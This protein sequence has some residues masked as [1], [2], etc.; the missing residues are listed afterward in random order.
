MKPTSPP[1]PAAEPLHE[2]EDARNSV[3]SSASAVDEITRLAAWICETPI[4]LVTL[5]DGGAH[6]LESVT[7][8]TLPSTWLDT[9][10]SPHTV[11]QRGVLLISD[12]AADHRVA[13]AP[14]VAGEPH[15]RFYAGTPLLDIDGQPIGALSAMDS[16]TRSLTREQQSALQILGRQVVAQLELRDQRL[17][18]EQTEAISDVRVRAGDSVAVQG[19]E[20]FAD[21]LDEECRR[22]GRYNRPLSLLLLSA[23]SFHGSFDQPADGLLSAVAHWL[24]TSARSSDVVGCL[25]P[26]EFAVLLTDTDHA[27][28]LVLGERFRQI[29]TWA[30]WEHG[31]VLVHAGIVS[32][33]TGGNAS[34]LVQEA[35]SALR[36]AQERSATT[37]SPA[38]H[39]R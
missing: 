2:R 23:D 14:I 21:R 8:L 4:A 16:V 6:R 37:V 7:G 9:C 36:R 32:L 19:S 33:A 30:G 20:A 22:A 27:G 29:V 11:K 39:A 25:K 31:P 34:T 12:A 1:E 24:A 17:S 35:R 38:R 26:D 28:A 13:A 10:F 3:V 18:Q 15:I 5:T